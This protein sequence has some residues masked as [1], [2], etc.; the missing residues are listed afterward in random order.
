M[1]KAQEYTDILLADDDEDDVIVFK[2]A[3][4]DLPG[5]ILLTHVNDG[6]K[7]LLKLEEMLPDIIFLDINMP[8]KDGKQCLKEIRA[9]RRY[10][11]VPVV[12]LTSLGYTSYIE[13]T[14][15]AGANLFVIKP[16]SISDLTNKISRILNISWKEFIYYPPRDEF[17]L[18]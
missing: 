9:N 3:V 16:A 12:M 15:N 13:E 10:D 6:E 17:V 8:C 4:K 7:L 1:N 14:Y 2:L 5:T 18:S 11:V